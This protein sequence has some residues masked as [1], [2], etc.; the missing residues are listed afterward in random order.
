MES[1][2]NKSYPGRIQSVKLVAGVLMLMV[3][4]SLI[5]G[6]FLDVLGIEYSLE[7]PFI[8]IMTIIVSMVS[9]G[10]VIWYV[11]KN[12]NIW[13]GIGAFLVGVFVAWLF[14]KTGSLYI[15]IFAHFINNLLVVLAVQYTSIPGFSAASETG[16]QTLWFTLTGLIILITAIFLIEKGSE[17]S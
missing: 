12:M 17:L 5:L 15:A 9:L 8:Y 1:E 6:I 4:S 11:M 3:F 2:E 16:F 7:N 14:F 10:G 13:Q